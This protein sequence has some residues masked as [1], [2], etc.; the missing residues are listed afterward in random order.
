MRRL[1]IHLVER[2]VQ[3]ES[4][5]L[6]QRR[7][8]VDFFERSRD[9]DPESDSIVR[10]EISKLRRSLRKSKNSSYSKGC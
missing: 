1:L 5:S 4:H 6:T 3:G 7:L 9:F 2:T 8:A 10:V